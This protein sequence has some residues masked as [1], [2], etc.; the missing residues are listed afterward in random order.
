MLC[1]NSC[2]VNKNRP[3]PLFLSFEWIPLQVLPY[4]GKWEQWLHCSPFGIFAAAAAAA[5]AA[6]NA[7]AANVTAA[8]RCRHCCRSG[9]GTNQLELEGIW[10]ERNCLQFCGNAIPGLI[11]KSEEFD[12]QPP[13]TNSYFKYKFVLATPVTGVGKTRQP[14]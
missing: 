13:G 1:C 2:A 4:S 9:V 10:R 5:P 6:A 14:T 3:F 8:T 11:C 7:T 12:I